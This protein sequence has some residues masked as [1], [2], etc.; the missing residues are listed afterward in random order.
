M[1]M[2]Q[3][4]FIGYTQDERGQNHR[5]PFFLDDVADFSVI[6]HGGVDHFYA[7][8][9]ATQSGRMAI[10]AQIDSKTFQELKGLRHARTV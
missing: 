10:Q 5:V 2:S 6:K 9:N 3:R 1:L 8:L 7:N 4:L